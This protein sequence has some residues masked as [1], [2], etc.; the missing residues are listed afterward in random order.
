MTVFG[1][2]FGVQAALAL[3]NNPTPTRATCRA[4]GT[5]APRVE[6]LT[7]TECEVDERLAAD[8]RRDKVREAWVALRPTGSDR[9]SPVAVV[10]DVEDPGVLAAL[11]TGGTMDAAVR[12]RLASPTGVPRPSDAL[13]V[14]ARRLLGEQGIELADDVVVIRMGDRPS[15][16]RALAWLGLGA[17]GIAALAMTLLSVWFPTHD[18]EVARPTSPDDGSLLS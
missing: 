16:Q 12:A 11:P 8:V 1:F 7:L 10:V 13:G 3:A 18:V 2:G 9:T 14:R 15:L 6:W 5:E 4:L 17:L